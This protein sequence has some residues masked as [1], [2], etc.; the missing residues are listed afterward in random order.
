MLSGV[1]AQVHLKMGP[2]TPLIYPVVISPV[3]ECI[4]EIVPLSNCSLIHGMWAIL[5]GKAKWKQL[6]LPLPLKRLNLK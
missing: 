2:M 4:I 1:L 6:E 5:V 3:P